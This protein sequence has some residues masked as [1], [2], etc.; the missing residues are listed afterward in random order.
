MPSARGEHALGTQARAAIE[1]PYNTPMW[2]KRHLER[3]GRHDGPVVLAAAAS[4]GVPHL[5]SA[6]V[7]EARPLVWLEL[8][9]ELGP[10]K[11]VVTMAAD[12]GA[13]YVSTALFEA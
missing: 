5:I 9:R 12:S 6:L 13:R 10:G 8:A 1:F 7:E 2:C 3:L 11:V 4:W